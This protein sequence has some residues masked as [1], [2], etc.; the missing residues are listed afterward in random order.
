MLVGI[1]NKLPARLLCIKATE[2]MEYRYH[3]DSGG[4]RIGRPVIEVAPGMENIDFWV[5]RPPTQDSLY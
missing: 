2:K 3:G 1:F 4:S 5:L